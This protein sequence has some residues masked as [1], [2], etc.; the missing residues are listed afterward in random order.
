MAA[1]A[2][3][4]VGLAAKRVA[5]KIPVGYLVLGA[6][7]LDFLWFAFWLAGIEQSAKP[8][9]MAPPVWSHSL[10]MATIW[11][12]L[13]A[14]IAARIGHSRR[15]GVV[16]GLVVFS[17]WVVD[18]ITHPMTAVYPPDKGIPLW[19]HGSPLVGLGLYRHMFGVYAGEF[20]TFA[21]GTIVYILARRRLKRISVRAAQA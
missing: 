13:A 3:L 11:S 21:L 4:G 2:H 8:G 12:G 20:G 6:Y 19:F 1:L 17:H 15:T 5:P 10:V 18:F 16:F 14:L 7:A 9:G